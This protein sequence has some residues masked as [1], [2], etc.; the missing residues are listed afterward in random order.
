MLK[1]F[2]FSFFKSYM[3][4]KIILS[5]NQKKQKLQLNKLNICS[6]FHNCKYYVVKLSNRNCNQQFLFKYISC[7]LL[8]F[9]LKRIILQINEFENWQVQGLNILYRSCSEIN[10]KVNKKDTF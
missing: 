3:R 1:L 5:L 7:F 2:D 8:I 10:N 9:H 6:N 4:F